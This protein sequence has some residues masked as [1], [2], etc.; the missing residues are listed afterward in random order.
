MSRTAF[1]ISL[2]LLMAA[3]PAKP[4]APEK[5]TLNKVEVKPTPK[6]FVVSQENS[7]ILFV[8]AKTSRS[9]EGKFLSFTG[10]ISLPDPKDLTTSS[11]NVEIRMTDFETDAVNLTAHLKSVDFFDVERF[12]VATFRSTQVSKVDDS[13]YNIVGDLDFHGV[14]K[15]ITIPAKIE[16]KEGEIIASSSF[17]LNRG[18]F[19]VTYPGMAND[20]IKN[21]VQLKIDL[22]ATLKP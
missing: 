15:S 6:T 5:P 20:P 11:V 17:A 2:G 19:Q 13:T 7:S 4:K 10:E 22:R 12:P 16:P 8:G 14:K 18:D 21:E 9:H 3:C 1:C